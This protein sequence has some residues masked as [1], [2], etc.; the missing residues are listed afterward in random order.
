[1]KEHFVT[2]MDKVFKN[3]HAETAPPLKDGEECW[4]LPLLGVYHPRKS[5]QIMV[6]F[7]SSAKYKDVSLNES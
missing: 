4:Y 1:M 6:V 7:D 5:K 2:F 3:K